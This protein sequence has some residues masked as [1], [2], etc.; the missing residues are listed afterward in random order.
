MND[1]KNYNIPNFKDE[2]DVKFKRTINIIIVTVL[3]LG[4]VIGSMFLGKAL[5]IDE[6]NLSVYT[7]NY[8]DFSFEIRSDYQVDNNYNYDYLLLLD[9]DNTWN[10]NLMIVDES[11]STV[12]TYKEDLF[13]QI[14]NQGY[15]VSKYDIKK[16][17]GYEWLVYEVIKNNL[18]TIICFTKAT[19]TKTFLG[20][21]YNRSNTID[22][23]ILKEVEVILK[24]AKYNTAGVDLRPDPVYKPFIFNKENNE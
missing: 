22:Y 13:T 11:Y 14:E 3:L 7:T 15:D 6:D 19:D 10:F 23:D 8:H 21:A 12:L 4:V 18:K 20:Y 24:T 5:L 2:K 9:K 16:I 1:N 17:G